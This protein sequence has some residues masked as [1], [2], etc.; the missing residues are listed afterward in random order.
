M[1]TMNSGLRGQYTGVKKLL[2]FASHPG[3]RGDCCCPS[4]DHLVRGPPVRRALGLTLVA[5]LQMRKLQAKR[6]LHVLE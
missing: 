5:I 6:L 3:M 2:R 1:R 4:M